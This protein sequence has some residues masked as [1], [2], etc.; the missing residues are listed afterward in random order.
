MSSFTFAP[1]LGWVAGSV[2]AATMAVAAVAVIW[3]HAVRRGAS[4]ETP[5]MC[6]RRC[7]ACVLVALMALTPCIAT[8]TTTRAVSATDVVIATDVTKSMDVADATY[9]DQEGISRLEAARLAIDDIVKAYPNSSYAG[10]SFGAQG[11]LDVPL[12]PDAQAIDN[13]ADALETEPASVVSGSLMDSALDALQ[14][15]LEHLHESRPD[16]TVIL[17]VITDGEQTVPHLRRTFSALRP[18][19]KDS[20]VIGVGSTQGGKVPKSAGSDQWVLDPDTGQPGVSVMDAEQ[21]KAIAD[22]LGGS[23]ILTADGMTVADR[24]IEGEAKRWTQTQSVKERTH[25]APVTWPL[26]MLLLAVLAWEAG[27]WLAQSRRLVR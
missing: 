25:L 12:T 27:A 20:C 22:E 17:Y 18:F 14:R 2:I 11:T 13:W 1:A 9:G 5:G 6:I 21:V 8:T 4:D 7:A 10:I 16:D 23:S 19:V 15:T 3:L 26:T 24:S